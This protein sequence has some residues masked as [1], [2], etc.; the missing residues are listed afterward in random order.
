MELIRGTYQEVAWA[1]LGSA[2]GDLYVRAYAMY[3]AQDIA[4]NRSYVYYKATAYFSGSY[5][6]DQQCI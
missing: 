6:Y 4:N 3:T 5:I 2:S 1:Y